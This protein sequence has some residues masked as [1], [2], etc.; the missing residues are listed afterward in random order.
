[1][2][3]VRITASQFEENFDEYF[4]YVM[5]GNILYVDDAVFIPIE[6]YERLTESIADEKNRLSQGGTSAFNPE[7]EGSTPS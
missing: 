3:D 7:V 2:S 4:D 6:E 5:N 1:M